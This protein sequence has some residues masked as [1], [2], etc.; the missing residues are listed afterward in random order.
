[1][2]A[3]HLPGHRGAAGGPQRPGAPPDGH[4]QVPAVHWLGGNGTAVRRVTPAAAY[5]VAVAPLPDVPLEDVPDRLAAL[6]TASGVRGGCRP[7]TS[8]RWPCAALTDGASPGKCPG[9]GLGGG[10]SSPWGLAE[11]LLETGVGR[12]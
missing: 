11:P 2:P 5:T 3:P 4:V 8:S 7:P 10:H 6:S 12:R 1:M 9:T